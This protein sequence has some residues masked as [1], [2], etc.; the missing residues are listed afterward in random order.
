MSKAASNNAQG[1]SPET[2][3]TMSLGQMLTVARANSAMGI[4]EVAAKLFLS[5]EVVHQLETDTVP[6]SANTLFTKGYV[7]SYCNLLEIPPEQYIEQF[8]LQYQ[9]NSDVKKMQTFSNR[10]KQN[11]HNNYLNWITTIVVIILLMAI[12]GW[13]WQQTPVESEPVVDIEFIT[14]SIEPSPL[15]PITPNIPVQSVT[16]DKVSSTLSFSKDCWI[17]I[18]DATNAVVA[19]GIKKAGTQLQISG[20]APLEVVLGAP[21]GVEITYQQQSIDFSS[22]I[23]NETA[24]FTLPLEQ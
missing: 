2:Q 5:A 24:T 12:V 19:V 16:I 10:T 15:L 14:Q 8:T 6:D 17:K 4:D 23:S 11:T 22:Y 20:V 7:K 1:D 13:W 21:S 18:T 3:V 9:C